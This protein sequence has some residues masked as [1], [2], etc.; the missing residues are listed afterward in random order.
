MRGNGTPWLTLRAFF[1]MHKSNTVMDNHTF[2]NYKLFSR[3]R[4][5]EV[6]FIPYPN[7]PTTSA[8]FPTPYIDDSKHSYPSSSSQHTFY[9]ILLA[10]IRDP[11]QNKLDLEQALYLPI[12][13]STK[14]GQ[15]PRKSLQIIW[16]LRLVLQSRQMYKLHR[17]SY[18]YM[19][20]EDY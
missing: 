19:L 13:S 12:I 14:K 20:R 5:N 7:F 6:S 9:P 15:L 10:E 8:A 16:L 18:R 3:P 2:N 17:H 11:I 1:R 4:T